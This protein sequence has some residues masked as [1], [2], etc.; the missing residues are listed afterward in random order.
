MNTRLW[1]IR[2]A[3]PLIEP[4]ICYGSLDVRADEAAALQLATELVRELPQGIT[5]MHSPLQ[6]CEQTIE[7][8]CAQ[9]ADF[10]YKR[11][12]R[13]A[14]MHFGAWEG[15]RWDDIVRSELDAWTDDFAHYR[16]GSN[17]GQVG[18]CVHELLQRVAQALMESA[19]YAQLAW[20]T[21]AGVI[22]VVDWLLAQEA[23]K[24]G[25]IR[26]FA[27]LTVAQA[28]HD[29][30]HAPSLHALRASDWPLNAPDFGHHHLVSVPNLLA[31]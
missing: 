20:L 21:H 2:H 23:R 10:S 24:A 27:G 6:R 15:Q 14:E 9:N 8:L 12:Q 13:I 22:R 30:A 11:D 3:R 18:E 5:L 17:E 19:Q 29:C 16:C 28:R 1:L 25:T 31:D 7:Y 4:G 26:F